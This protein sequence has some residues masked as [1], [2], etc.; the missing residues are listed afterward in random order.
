[1]TIRPSSLRGT[2]HLL[3]NGWHH[4]DGCSCHDC[5]PH[6]DAPSAASIAPIA[7]AAR[8][9]VTE[10]SRLE[11]PTGQSVAYRLDDITDRSSRLAQRR[12][13]VG[14]C[15]RPQCRCLAATVRYR[16]EKLLSCGVIQVGAVVDPHTVGLDM[17]A[18]IFLEIAPG[19]V[20]EVAERFAALQE[21][22]F[23]AGSIGN[24]DLSIQVCLRD[25][26]A[27]RRFIDKVVGHMPGVTRAR[28][29]LFPGSSRTSMNATSPASADKDQVRPET[30]V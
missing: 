30:E 15:P 26:D 24:G 2:E 16:I 13:H 20:R 19:Q 28:T 6:K 14:R 12:A 4:L 25:S 29:I 21:V 10:P 18:D 11:P 3:D 1:M 17:I 27:L 22:S 7:V 9:N 23:V 8:R 5:A